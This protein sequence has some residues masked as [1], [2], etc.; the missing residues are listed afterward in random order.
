MKKLLILLAAVLFATVVSAQNA[1]KEPEALVK[2]RAAYQKAFDA[3]LT[4]YLIALGRLVV[5]PD[6]KDNQDRVKAIQKDLSLLAAQVLATKVQTDADKKQ[7]KEV[8]G[9]WTYKAGRR[10]SGMQYYANHTVA[11]SAAV[12]IWWV[13]KGDLMTR[14]SKTIWDCQPAGPNQMDGKA[15]ELGQAVEFEKFELLFSNRK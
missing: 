9:H 2:S 7:E 5:T 4:D 14:W 13:E 3:A 10:L 1:A 12:G 15:F 11:S 8:V 6:G